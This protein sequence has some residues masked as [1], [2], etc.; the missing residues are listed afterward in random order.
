MS[1]EEE[2]DVV[3][4]D[5]GEPVA[6]ERKIVNG[7]EVFVMPEKKRKDLEERLRSKLPEPEPKSSEAKSSWWRLRK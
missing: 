7:V 4:F 1:K 5:R 3:I 6:L 2:G